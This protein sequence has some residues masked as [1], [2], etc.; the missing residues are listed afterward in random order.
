MRWGT[1]EWRTDG[2]KFREFLNLSGEIDHLLQVGL[3]IRSLRQEKVNKV[4]LF[5]EEI[6]KQQAKTVVK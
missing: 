3:Q 1:G 2:G 5:Q 4:H 6:Q